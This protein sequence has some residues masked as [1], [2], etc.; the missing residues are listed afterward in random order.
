MGFNDL[1]RQPKSN[2]G[3][4]KVYIDGP[5]GTFGEVQTSVIQAQAQGDFVYGFQIQLF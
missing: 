3:A 4:N 1:K 5:G 2:E